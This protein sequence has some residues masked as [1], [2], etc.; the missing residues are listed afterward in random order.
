MGVAFDADMTEF[1]TAPHI[2]DLHAPDLSY[3]VARLRQQRLGVGGHAVR[4]NPEP[5]R[6]RFRTEFFH[7]R[8]IAIDLGWLRAVER[9]DKGRERCVRRQPLDPSCR[10]GRYGEE[11]W[12]AMDNFAGLDHG[13]ESPPRQAL[14][15]LVAQLIAKGSTGDLDEL[16]PTPGKHAAKARRTA[17]S[18]NQIIV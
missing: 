11:E 4:A 16:V 1:H 10:I 8:A 15:R 18:D 14:R 9:G 13:Q 12:T 5:S 17:G 6:E 3:N 2:V 7:H